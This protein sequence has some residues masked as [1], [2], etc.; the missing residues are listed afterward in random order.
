MRA[1]AIFVGLLL[2]L[3]AVPTVYALY[4]RPDLEK[5]P[6]QRL[7][8]NLEMSLEDDPKNVELRYNLARVYAMAWAL[9]SD[10]IEV[11]KGKEKMGAWFGFEPSNVPFKPVKTDDKEKM[12][13]ARKMLAK[14][15]NTYEEVVKMDPN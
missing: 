8:D 3:A 1:A 11:Q 5:I 7:I 9:K 15:I 2:P 12:E 6:V 10:T 4:A 13:A 14:A